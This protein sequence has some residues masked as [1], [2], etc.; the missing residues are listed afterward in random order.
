M[1]QETLPELLLPFGAARLLWLVKEVSQVL[2]IALKASWTVM[3]LLLTVVVFLVEHGQPAVVMA[4][5]GVQL[6][7]IGPSTRSEM[8]AAFQVDWPW[9]LQC[10]YGNDG[11]KERK[12]KLSGVLMDASDHHDGERDIKLH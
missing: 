9:L 4:L 5:M 1:G 6:V 2:E 7:R 11:K 8:A 12:W 10:L 3:V